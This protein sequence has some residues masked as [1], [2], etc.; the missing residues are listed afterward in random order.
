MR[1]PAR[2]IKQL[3]SKAYWSSFDNTPELVVLFAQRPGARCRPRADP[4]LI[5]YAFGLNVVPATPAT[6]MTL[7][8]TVA[9]SWRTDAIAPGRCLDPPARCRTAPAHRQCPY[10][11]RPCRV[12]L[13]RAVESYNLRSG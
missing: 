4:D 10:P 8:R 3:S 7:L 9:L 5:E 6:L 12:S 1:G 11:H 2:H 13:R